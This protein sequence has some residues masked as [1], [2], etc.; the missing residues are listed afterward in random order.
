M[1]DHGMLFQ[2]ET[3]AFCSHEVDQWV[4][5]LWRLIEIA[6][7]KLKQLIMS[8]LCYSEISAMK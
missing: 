8:L 1:K 6:C 5:Q 7:R 4:R 2:V 3:C